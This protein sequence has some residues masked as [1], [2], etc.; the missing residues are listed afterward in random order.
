MKRHR[1]RWMI[2]GICALLVACGGGGGG[3][4]GSTTPP[5]SSGGSAPTP[6]P[7]AGACSI[8][9]E[10][11]FVLDVARS[12]YLFLDLLPPSVNTAQYPTADALLD[13]LTA[14]ARSQSRDRYFSYLTS[15]T[16]E[17][18]YFQQGESVGFGF[19]VVPPI[20]GT[21]L[22]VTDV[23]A[24]S[25]AAEAGF[26]RGDEILAIGT[27]SNDLQPVSQLLVQ[28]NGWQAAIGPSQSG[29]TRVFRVRTREGTIV[30]RTA[31]K[32]PFSL[33]PV[34]RTAVIAR[35]GLTPVGYV[36]LRS[37]IEPA[38]VALAAAFETFR[39]QNVSDVII[40]L[41]YN[42][43]GLLS[44]ADLLVNLLAGARGTTD[45]ELQVKHNALHA[46]E[47]EI[48]FFRPHPSAVQ[49]DR[50][51]F[52]VTDASASASEMVIN[53]L[54]PYADVALVG[55]R[56]Y[57]K[58][59]GQY[60]FDLEGCDTRLRL[61]TFK[62]TNRDGYGDYYT[63]LPPDPPDARFAE[64]FCSANDDLMSDPGDPDEAMTAEALFWL[65]NGSCSDAVS[66]IARA[67]LS[68]ERPEPAPFTHRPAPLEVYLPGA[69]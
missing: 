33:D 62:L 1:Y 63:G 29:I 61:V 50:I 56:T 42:G 26:Q 17:E 34:P 23:Y 59:V 24:G 45:I 21:R 60:A 39:A 2:S 20:P 53:S 52:L 41:R 27:S 31:T 8:E 68:A 57:G 9:S 13:V 47:D 10:K 19:S 38:N 58:P 3:S 64:S 43:G 44:T 67:T 25:G 15:I 7:S 14:Q 35:E 49:A 12:W 28:P 4:S 11:Q 32:R 37:F 36:N 66:G 69:L 46:D 48:V 6:P 5:P 30:E 51:V 18:Q 40:D 16:A 55:E 54:A 65:A 22:F